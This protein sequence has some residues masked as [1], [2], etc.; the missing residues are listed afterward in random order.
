MLVFF[1]IPYTNIQTSKFKTSPSKDCI[2]LANLLLVASTRCTLW[3]DNMVGCT[4]H[5]WTRTMHVLILIWQQ[6]SNCFMV[7]VLQL[8]SFYICKSNAE[9]DSLFRTCIIYDYFCYEYG[10][11]TS[12]YLPLDFSECKW[13]KGGHIYISCSTKK[14]PAWAG[15]LAVRYSE[16]NAT[17]NSKY[18][19]VHSMR[20]VKQR[21]KTKKIE[22]TKVCMWLQ[23]EWRRI[24]VI[25]VN[26]EIGSMC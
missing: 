26:V 1:H 14:G 9:V 11:P 20:N 19:K 16:P 15:F 5:L 24:W 22:V 17:F 7:R 3:N 12:I 13:N 18:L 10:K 4:T 8:L 6:L 23:W 2:N 21:K 25:T